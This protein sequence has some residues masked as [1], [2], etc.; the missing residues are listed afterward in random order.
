MAGGN[1]KLGL[2]GR[3][4]GMTR[5]YLE[6][7][8]SIP[9]TAIEVEPAVVTQVRTTETDGYSAVQI[10]S[11][12]ARPRRS[13]FQIMGHDSKAGSGPKAVHVE[14]RMDEAEAG[15][16][17]VGQALSVDHF[18][19]FK[20]VDVTGTSKGK[21]FAGTM[22]RHN[23]KGL[24]ASHGVERKH[25]APGSIGGHANNA[26]KAGRIKKGKKMNGQMGDERVTVRNLDVVRVEADR[27]LLLVKGAVPGANGGVVRIRPSVRLRP[28]KH[29][30]QEAAAQAAAAG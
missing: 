17:E 27:N 13:T 6:N 15:E 18:S 26:G 25:R 10:G 3:K 16:F 8:V 21:G 19:G 29:A 30:A 11:V 7:G 22:K 24:R 12:D 4:I 5:V 2:V 9:V 23:F 1:A 14:F 20:Y 28:T